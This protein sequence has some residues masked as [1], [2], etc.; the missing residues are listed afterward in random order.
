MFWASANNVDSLLQQVFR[1][2]LSDNADLFKVESRKGHSTEAFGVALEL[3]NPRARVSRSQGRSRIFSGLGE[4]AWYLSA[5]DS[6]SFIENYL[7]RYGE[8]SDD[9]VT[10]NGAYGKRIFGNAPNSNWRR[11]IATLKG[12][13]GSRNGVIQIFANADAETAG[14]DIP[15]TCTMQFAFRD[16]R[17]HLQVH[18]RSNDAFLGLPHDI[19]SFTMLQEI[20]ARELGCEVGT[21]HHSVGSLHLYD[22]NEFGASRTMAQQYLDEGLHDE[23]PMPHMPETDPWAAI[24]QML[25]AERQIRIG[26]ITY[27]PPSDLSVYWRDLITLYKVYAARK[28]EDPAAAIKSL[29][30]QISSPVYRTF[31][32]DRLDKKLGANDTAYN[33]LRNE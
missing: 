27:E 12:R 24:E 14:N 11:V 32:L 2:L 6:I 9:G 15:C 4:L 10:A 22:D 17:L 26:D 7:E 18:M 33:L 30:G 5:D 19:F 1:H 25:E 21:Y 8:F 29:L 23:V 16:D 28:V 20:A 13:P 3:T 31:V